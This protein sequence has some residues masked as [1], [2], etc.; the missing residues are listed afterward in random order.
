MLCRIHYV[1]AAAVFVAASQELAFAQANPF[2][3]RTSVQEFPESLEWLNS[4]PLSKSDL[5]GKFV[6]LDFW[7]Y[8]CINCLHIL[9]ELKKLEEQFP[10]NLV[11]IG[12]HSAKFD[13]EKITD[14]IREAILRYEI[15]HPVIN[16]AD[17][18]LWK[19]FQVNVWPTI[20]LLDP[21]GMKVRQQA[22]EFKAEEI[23]KVLVAAIPHYRNRRLLDEVPL[24]FEL[25]SS[26]ETETP[27]RFPGKVL[28]DERNGRLIISDSNHNRIVITTPQGELLDVIGAGTV[29]RMDGDFITATFHHPQ[30]CALAGDMLF[31]ADT[32]NH[33]VRKIDLSKKTVTTV[34]GTG[35]QGT[36][37]DAF[38][39][40]NGRVVNG[41]RRQ[42]SG[43]P[44][45][46]PLSS[47]WALAI[48]GNNLFI[49]MAGYH[50]IWRYALDGSQIGPFAGNGREDIVDG[51]RLSG[52]PYEGG[53]SF[54]QPSGLSTDGQW[55]YVADSE[56][57]SIRAV[58]L[59][60]N[61]HV[62]TVVGTSH[63]AQDRL[64]SFGDIDGRPGIARFQ[65]CLDVVAQGGKLYVADT[66]NHKIKVIDLKSGETKTLSGTGRPGARDNPPQ[67][68][69]PAGLAA[70][71]GKLYVA[72][73]NN[74]L[75][76]AIDLASGQVSTDSIAGLAAPTSAL[77][78][79]GS[80]STQ[81]STTDVRSPS[82]KP[83]FV[84]AHRVKIQPA[85]V[86][87]SD[88]MVKLRVS[89][90]LP[91]GWK[92]NPLAP[93]S[94]WL[95]SPRESGIVDR[96]EFGRKSLDQPA[97]EFSVPVRI[98]GTGD[99]EVEVSLNYNYC[100]LQDNGVCKFGA[101][102]FSVPLR[103]ASDAESSTIELVHAVPD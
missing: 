82:S 6:L 56:G 36:S 35:Q 26:K 42:W 87:A 12:V 80:S 91:N 94:Y 63:L 85:R 7:T 10:N 62:R 103:T 67:F 31:V 11:V 18:R 32:E 9:P 70:L 60:G 100:Q 33:L 14:N 77:A 27:L 54:A 22:G 17:L 74:H 69:E 98:N 64:F 29:G 75:L 2:P 96:A 88:G 58:P 41:P 76:R 19:A 48:H 92:I 101:V 72:D 59:E 78:T 13:T 8:C 81:S 38:P 73:T 89:L 39:G 84:G 66:Y 24:K 15:S 50:Q 44:L 79:R 52:K 51:V 4:R 21:Q 83:S 5:K 30:G 45:R 23:R 68:H 97:A 102:T 55:L 37:I 40:W 49:A 95:D 90:K 34:A 3:Q 1:F 93:M 57:S 65:H 20:V 46:T 43:R 61:E 28:S 16:D 25:E 53:S 47:P 99:D 86:N 71:N